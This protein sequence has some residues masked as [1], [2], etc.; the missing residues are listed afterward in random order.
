[1]PSQ[2]FEK[3]AAGGPDIGNLGF[4][5]NAADGPDAGNLGF[6]HVRNTIPFK[7]FSIKRIPKWQING[8]R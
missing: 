8:A 2:G 7:L 4:G 5:K 6:A 1:M 3:F